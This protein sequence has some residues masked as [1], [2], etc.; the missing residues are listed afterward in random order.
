MGGQAATAAEFAVAIRAVRRS[1]SRCRC[2]PKALTAGAR[3][4]RLARVLRVEKGRD[5]RATEAIC[6]DRS[7]CLGSTFQAAR[8]VVVAAGNVG[9]PLLLA[10]DN[11]ASSSDQVRRNLFYPR[12]LVAL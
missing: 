9:T 1:R 10:S 7:T 3:L 11:L 4:R 8:I 5:G 2:G 12:T 6:I